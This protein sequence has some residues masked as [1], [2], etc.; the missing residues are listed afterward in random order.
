MRRLFQPLLLIGILL[1]QAGNLPAQ[2]PHTLSSPAFSILED[3]AR[4]ID[5][6]SAWRLYQGGRFSSLQDLYINP[7][8][9]RSVFWVAL[10]P[11]RLSA[12]AQQVLLVN[13]AHI[14][15]LEWYGVGTDSVIQPLAF[16]GDA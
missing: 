3:T 1:L 11:G 13:N 16:T 8:F 10:A 9:T 2:T 5:A 6:K 15:Y 12:A 7:G 4:T 14:N